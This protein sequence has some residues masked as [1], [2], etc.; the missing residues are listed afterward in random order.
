MRDTSGFYNRFPRLF[1]GASAER[2]RHGNDDL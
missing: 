1:S 2:E